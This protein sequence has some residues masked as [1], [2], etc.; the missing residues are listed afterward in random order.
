MCNADT[1]A[2]M[3]LRPREPVVFFASV[4]QVAAVRVRLRVAMDV[5]T[6]L[7]VRRAMQHLLLDA[8]R[9]S[10]P[11]GFVTPAQ[12][13]GSQFAIIEGAASAEDVRVAPA[14][15]SAPFPWLLLLLVAIVVWFMLKFIV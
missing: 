13:F 3:L 4:G 9:A 5:Y 11:V 12:L 7:L 2:R 15:D 6:A 14:A 8:P 10:D 1:R